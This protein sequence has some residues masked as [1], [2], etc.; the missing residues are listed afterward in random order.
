MVTSKLGANV[1]T[2]SQDELHKLFLRFLIPTF[3]EVFATPPERAKRLP[4]ESQM[5]QQSASQRPK[6][7]A[8]P[9]TPPRMDPK[10]WT[11]KFRRGKPERGGNNSISI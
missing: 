4:P 11:R 5:E 7:R 2:G 10:F 6:M 9:S 1:D 8:Q 3:P